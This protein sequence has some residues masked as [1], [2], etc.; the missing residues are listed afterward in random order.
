MGGGAVGTANGTLT[1]DCPPEPSG[2]TA[3]HLTFPHDK[4][5]GGT[6]P[7]KVSAQVGKHSPVSKEGPFDCS[8]QH[9]GPKRLQY[10]FFDNSTPRNSIGGNSELL[11]VENGATADIYID[12]PSV[13]EITSW[14]KLSLL[15][16]NT[17]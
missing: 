8:D 16:V 1:V 4:W 12:L 9:N 13:F 3:M 2:D 6:A 11:Y 5:V 15:P 14:S 7:G 17:A 10:H